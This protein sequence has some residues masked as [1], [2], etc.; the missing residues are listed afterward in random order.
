MNNRWPKSLRTLGTRLVMRFKAT[1][2]LML[3]HNNAGQGAPALA[4][5]RGFLSL[6]GRPERWHFTADF[7]FLGLVSV[8]PG[9]FLV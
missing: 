4:Q 1:R 8:S 6:S 5:T 3:R 9:D 7:A 2:E